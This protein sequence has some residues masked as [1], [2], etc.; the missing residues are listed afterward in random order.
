MISDSDGKNYPWY[1]S[2][3][4][5]VLVKGPQQDAK[6]YSVSM[7]DNFYPHVTWDIP[8]SREKIP[9]LTHIRR[10]QTFYT[11]LVA[12]DLI[13]GQLIVLKT[14]E[15]RMTLE[16]AVSPNKKLGSRAKLISNQEPQQPKVHKKNIP[17]PNSAL[18][19]ANANS[20]QTLVWRPSKNSPEIVVPPKYVL[21]E[22]DGVKRRYLTYNFKQ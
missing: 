9:R 5:V 6:T 18:Y 19:P 17:I 1:G 8:T 2:N 20:A 21:I 14:I 12:M 4:E 3:R 13:S 16:I 11:W 22:K 10:D 15:W 7:N